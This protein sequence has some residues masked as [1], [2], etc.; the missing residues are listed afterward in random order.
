M[1]IVSAGKTNTERA[2]LAVARELGIPC[3]KLQILATTG[4][5]QKTIYDASLDQNFA[6]SDVTLMLTYSHP[7]RWKWPLARASDRHFQ[8]HT[9]WVAIKWD[10]NVVAV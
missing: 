1:K 4:S 9:M 6:K 2:A 5:R 3:E 8:K 7:P 10:Q